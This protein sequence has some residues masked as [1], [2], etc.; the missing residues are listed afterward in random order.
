[1][2]PSVSTRW[3]SFPGRINRTQIIAGFGLVTE[4]DAE[5]FAGVLQRVEEDI[6][7]GGGELVAR[8]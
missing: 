8:R 5:V 6:G 1:M 2:F 7:T 4:L 3:L